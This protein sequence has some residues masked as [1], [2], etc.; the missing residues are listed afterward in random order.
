MAMP[1]RDLAVDR[2]INLAQVLKS[3]NIAESGGAAKQ[4]VADGQVRVNGS[5]ETRKRRQMA[6][7]DVVEVVGHEAIR[8]VQSP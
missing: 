1:M 8:L 3:A 7:G 6:I 4:L 5:L 2:A